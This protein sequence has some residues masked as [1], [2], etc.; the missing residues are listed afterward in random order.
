MN[1]TPQQLVALRLAID[2]GGKV[3]F[4][5]SFFSGRPLGA[6]V[7]AKSSAD[8]LQKHG[9]GLAILDQRDAGTF[10]I[11]DKG[12]VAYQEARRV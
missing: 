4:A 8:C 1:L 7:I 12:R 3:R 2:S 5:R 9:L 10:E 11:N 6:K